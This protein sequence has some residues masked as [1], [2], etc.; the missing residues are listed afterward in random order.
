MDAGDEGG[1]DSLVGGRTLEEI[2]REAIAAALRRTSG[3]RRAAADL[4]GLPRTTLSDR[5]RRFGLL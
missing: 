5:A 4:L 3:N 1:L 2:E